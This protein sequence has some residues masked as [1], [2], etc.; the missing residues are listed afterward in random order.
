MYC[1]NIVFSTE[2]K[3]LDGYSTGIHIWAFA[4]NIN[5]NLMGDDEQY[6]PTEANDYLNPEFRGK[7]ISTY[8]NDDDAV[9]Y[10]YKQIIDKY[11]WQWL[12]R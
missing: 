8:P 9:L 6:W 3:D 4:N 12:A 2:F 11:G 5:R 1:K 7:I 10:L